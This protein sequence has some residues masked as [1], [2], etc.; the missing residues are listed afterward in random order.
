MPSPLRGSATR[1]D[2][3][4]DRTALQSRR[5]FARRQWARRWLAW[6]FVVALFLLVA[7]VAA[8]VWAVYFSSLLAVQGVAV[9]GATTV[10]SARVRSAAAVPTG[11]P[12]AT[13]DL[14]Q[15]RARVEALALV[16][17]ADVTRQWP[18][19]VLIRVEERE[20]VAVVEIGGRLR[21]MDA[22]GVVFRDYRQAPPGLPHVLTSTDTRS[23]ALQEAARVVSAL[24]ADLAQ[25]VDHVEVES[26]D[27]ISLVL[28]DGRKVMW[29]SAEE[30]DQKAEVIAAL[31]VAKRAQEYD[32]SV[33][34]Q[35]TTR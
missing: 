1:A 32:V 2:P 15:V 35:P 3:P 22:D 7:V 34:G 26:V 8:G 14:D 30:S 12:L 16:R 20:A 4:A 17:S 10:G 18:D 31:L 33:P 24:P 27:Q 13:L 9:T 25:R 5:R 6:K 21:G 28:G 29:G 11:E 23:E 19:Q